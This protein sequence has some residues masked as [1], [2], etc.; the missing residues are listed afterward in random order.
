LSVVHSVRVTAGES[1]S[2][3]QEVALLEPRAASVLL[4]HFASKKCYP[5]SHGRC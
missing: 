5:V 4:L 1:L 2:I 3:K